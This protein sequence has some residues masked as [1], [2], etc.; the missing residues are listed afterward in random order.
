MNF[1]T[2]VDQTQVG[3]VVEDAGD[4][5]PDSDASASGEKKPQISPETLGL[6]GV[7]MVCGGVL[8]F[9]YLRNGPQSAGAAIAGAG[10]VAVVDQFL[11]NGEEHVKMMRNALDH[12]DQVVQEFR[13]YPL[14]AQVPL[15][16]L[17]TNPFR[18]SAPGGAVVESES[19]G[20]AKRRQE[21]ERAD[22]LKAA[23]SLQLLSVLRG[24]RDACL[25][26]N[27]LVEQGQQVEGFYI[28]KIGSD[29]VIVRKGSY[30]FELKMR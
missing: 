20:A 17:S 22:A 24:P 27:N 19:E 4:V 28:E 30:R 5:S 8:A 9:M 10:N 13:S 26:N 18:Q 16:E 14:R 15:S 3:E 7:L 21:Q 11:G 25:I 23:E 1:Q 6:I 29:S 2:M 12:T